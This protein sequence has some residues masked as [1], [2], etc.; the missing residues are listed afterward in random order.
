MQ[1][2]ENKNL[3]NSITRTTQCCTRFVQCDYPTIFF[4]TWQKIQS[5]ENLMICL[6]NGFH[7]PLVITLF[8]LNHLKISTL[9]AKFPS[10]F[11]T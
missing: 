6:D 2:S 11:P 10:I 8:S 5:V 3:A 1:I 4:D 7:Q 9:P